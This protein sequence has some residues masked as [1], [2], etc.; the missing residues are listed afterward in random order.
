M[1]TTIAT[2]LIGTLFLTA[3]VSSS[4]DANAE[5]Y[6]RLAEASTEFGKHLV[7]PVKA[8]ASNI[9]GN[10]FPV[11][12]L[13]TAGFAK[14][15]ALKVYVKRLSAATLA[16][17]NGT[18]VSVSPKRKGGCVVAMTNTGNLF[19]NTNALF[20]AL[21]GQGW[22]LDGAN[23]KRKRVFRRGDEAIVLDGGAYGSVSSFSL[24]PL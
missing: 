19:T 11:A 18:K 7:A 3:C 6:E 22:K 17:P 1:K 23:S 12:M 16:S 8:C 15:N 5:K 4:P 24:D 13:Q 21:H 14:A 2:T 10:G 20:S 9:S